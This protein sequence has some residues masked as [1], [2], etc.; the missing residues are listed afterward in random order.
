[1]LEKTRVA[2]PRSDVHF[3]HVLYDCAFRIGDLPLATAG[4]IPL[5]PLKP[6]KGFSAQV[7]LAIQ[8]PHQ[9]PLVVVAV[10]RHEPIGGAAQAFRHGRLRD[11]QFGRDLP[12]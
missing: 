5:T 7:L 2:V 6:T 11:A 4:V 1:L 12:L 3:N 8:G 9:L 10:L